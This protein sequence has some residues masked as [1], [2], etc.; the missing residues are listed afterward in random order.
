MDFFEKML[1]EVGE[2][3]KGSQH[4]KSEDLKDTEVKVKDVF[5]TVAPDFKFNKA[6][7]NRVL[8]F[9]Q[10]LRSNDANIKWFGGCLLGTDRIRFFDKDRDEW[11]DDVLEIDEDYLAMELEKTGL[12][13]N[14]SVSSDE[15]NN[16]CAWLIH[17][18]YEASPG[19]KE[20]YVHSACVA[21]LSILQFKLLTSLYFN[22]FNKALVDQPAA[23]ATYSAL[24]LKFRIKQLGSWQEMIEHRAERFL[25][26]DSPHGNTYR[27]F[28]EIN[29]IVYI[30]SDVSTRTRRTFYDYY[31]ILDGIR[32]TN[33]RLGVYNDTVTMEGEAIL[34]DVTRHQDIALNY[35]LTSSSNVSS[36]VTEAYLDVIFEMI[37]TSSSTAVRSALIAIAELPVGKQRSEMEEVM[38]KT[39]IITFEYI[40]V[41]EL[42]FTQIQYL[43]SKVRYIITAAKT[44]DPNILHIR[45]VVEKFI[46]KNTHLRHGTM[47]KS[48]R[49]AI[50]LYFIIKALSANKN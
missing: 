36:F 33:A 24:S 11:F 32:K 3:T 2:M 20:K 10:K 19:F 1:S 44:K 8:A 14:W 17:K 13:L 42:D 28:D 12:D 26:S 35:L 31:N 48:G 43:L 29:S 39:L 22:R 6:F 40:R 47:L 49:T 46:A 18:G 25:S 27:D 5:N 9:Y 41:N 30:M 4:L 50:L 38:R 37:T 23:E 45:K 34:K 16:T 21:I 7:S 15:F